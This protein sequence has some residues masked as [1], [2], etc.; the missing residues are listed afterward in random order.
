MDTKNKNEIYALEKQILFL[1]KRVVELEN[2]VFKLLCLSKSNV[3]K[4]SSKK[5]ELVL[6]LNE[7]KKKSNKTI[8]DKDTIYTIEMVLK[9]MK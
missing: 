5:M 9:N 2:E 7:L 1:Q 4:S 6:A 3:S 8:K